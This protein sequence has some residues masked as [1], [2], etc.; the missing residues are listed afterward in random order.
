MNVEALNINY[1]TATYKDKVV[2]IDGQPSTW[3]IKLINQLPE[4][5]VIYVYDKDLE[6]S[7]KTLF[8]IAEEVK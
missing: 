3:G 1:Y 6:T 2:V 5:K 4:S 7:L 8:H